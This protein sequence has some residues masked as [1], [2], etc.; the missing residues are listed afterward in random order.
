[1][2]SMTMSEGKKRREAREAR[3][4][5]QP[6]YDPQELYKDMELKQVRW[7]KLTQLPDWQVSWEVKVKAKREFHDA[8]ILYAK[9]IMNSDAARKKNKAAKDRRQR[10]KQVRE[11]LSRV[12]DGGQAAGG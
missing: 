4:A 6:K 7:L 2:T 9:F 12:T 1:M 5:R 3:L 10:G 11:G 8:L